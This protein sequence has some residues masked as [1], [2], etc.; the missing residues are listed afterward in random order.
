MGPVLPCM[1]IGAPVGSKERGHGGLQ[2]SSGRFL[3]PVHCLHLLGSHPWE[4]AWGGVH[5][6]WLPMLPASSPGQ[7]GMLSFTGRG[8][9]WEQ[10]G[11]PGPG[12]P[13]CI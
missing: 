12:L 8:G 11:K 4:A 6:D 1:A 13:T 3:R 7:A 2:G 5:G 10:Q 9:L